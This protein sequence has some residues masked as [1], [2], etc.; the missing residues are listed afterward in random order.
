RDFA[1][2]LATLEREDAEQE[3]ERARD[4]ETLRDVAGSLNEE[5]R[6][7]EEVTAQLQALLRHRSNVD[8]RLLAARDLV[9]DSAGLG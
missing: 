8:S 6:S 7:L 9:C 3:A 4:R 2:L 1:V 5:K